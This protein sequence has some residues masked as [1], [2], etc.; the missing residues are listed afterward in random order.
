MKDSS[1]S[2]KGKIIT[3]KLSHSNNKKSRNLNTKKIIF[4]II[5]FLTL[6]YCVKSEGSKPSIIYMKIS[7]PSPPSIERLLYICEVKPY[8]DYMPNEIYINDALVSFTACD[9]QNNFI[10]KENNVTLVCSL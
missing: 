8:A 9:L 3:D 1:K 2:L 10:E 6:F 4:L 7:I 5:V